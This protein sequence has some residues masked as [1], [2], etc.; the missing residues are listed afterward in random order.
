[1][2]LFSSDYF[3]QSELKR[4]SS[5]IDRKYAHNWLER[6]SR[7]LDE[8]GIIKNSKRYHPLGIVQFGVICYY[9]FLETKDSVYY[10]HFMNQIKY[11]KDSTKVHYLKGGTLIGLPYNYNHGGLKAPWYSGMTNGYALSFL[12]RYL[13]H[14][15]DE[16]IIP[17]IKKIASFLITPVEENGTLGKT[18]EGFLWIEEYPNYKK[19]PE[20]LNGY[21]N[22]LIGLK[23]YCDYFPKDLEKKVILDSTYQALKRTLHKYDS[24][25][26]WTCYN[27]AKAPCNDIYIQYEIFE[28]KHLYEIFGDVQFLDQMKLYC[29]YSAK[30]K[31]KMKPQDYKLATYIH[32][33]ALKEDGNYLK[34]KFNL[35]SYIL[36]NEKLESSFKKQQEKPAKKINFSIQVDSSKKTNYY[37]INYDSTEINKVKIKTKYYDYYGNSFSPKIKQSEATNTQLSYLLE[38][39][40]HISKIDVRLKNKKKNKMQLKS[41]EVSNT[42]AFTMPFY[43]FHKIPKKR[44]E[45][46]KYAYNFK[47]ESNTEDITVFYRNLKK[48]N[49]WKNFQNFKGMNG[50]F[51]IEEVG[52]YEFLIVYKPVMPVSHLSKIEISPK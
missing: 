51:S 30:K 16:S 49:A 40:N 4:Y 33:S 8:N 15:K 44:Y 25:N 26:N 5:H 35:S 50:E 47:E 11:F 32:G 18:P 39:E 28:M 27:R 17:I 37:A 46:G 41:C 20:V 14:T 22:G 12:L 2:L 48:K 42:V 7:T 31:L 6:G 36:N 29:F 23:E 52:I 9:E 24:P 45:V 10:H 3:G 13:E 1:M 19:S 21:I 34:T 43:V 38:D